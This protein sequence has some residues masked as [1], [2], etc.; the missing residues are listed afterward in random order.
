MAWVM[1]KG[2]HREMRNASDLARARIRT[3][4][5]RRRRCWNRGASRSEARVEH[6]RRCASGCWRLVQLLERG[7][8][9]GALPAACLAWRQQR[10]AHGAGGTSRRARCN[11]QGSHGAETIVGFKQS[12]SMMR[13][14][15]F[16]A[17]RI[18]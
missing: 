14:N 17:G 9:A 5:M 13:C 10:T 1:E 12:F 6:E 15:L 18:A 8:A 11:E 2:S 16:E 3:K 7:A 4:M